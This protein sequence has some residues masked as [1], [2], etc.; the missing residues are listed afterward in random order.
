MRCRRVRVR[1]RG[2]RSRLCRRVRVSGRR[3][4]AVVSS[5]ESKRDAAVLSNEGEGK[6]EEAVGQ[7]NGEV[8][9]VVG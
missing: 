2:G 6:E 9:G 8:G 7:G 3:W 4:E 5:G 1:A